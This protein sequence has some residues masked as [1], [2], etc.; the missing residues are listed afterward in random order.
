[1]KRFTLFLALI[2][3]LASGLAF[4]QR[5][6]RV[7]PRTPTNSEQRVALV[8]GNSGYKF[9]PLKNPV[10]DAKDIGAALKRLGFRVILRLD[11]TCNLA[12]AEVRKIG[13]VIV[14][15]SAGALWA[16]KRPSLSAPLLACGRQVETRVRLRGAVPGT[17]KTTGL[18]RSRARNPITGYS[19]PPENKKNRYQPKILVDIGGQCH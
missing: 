11:A 9:S 2:F 13:S 6:V 10:N 18:W 3:A 15:T 14:R 17:G 8:I 12:P 19:S 1:M 16:L 7:Q 4:A 5:A